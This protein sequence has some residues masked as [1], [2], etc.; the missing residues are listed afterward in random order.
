MRVPGWMSRRE[1]SGGNYPFGDLWN[2]RYVFMKTNEASGCPQSWCSVDASMRLAMEI[3][4][5]FQRVAFL[6]SR[7][8]L[9]HTRV[10]G[11][12]LR[13]SISAVY[14]EYHKAKTWK[15]HPYSPHMPRFDSMVSPTGSSSSL[16][17]TVSAGPR[18]L[19]PGPDTGH[20]DPAGSGHSAD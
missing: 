16:P 2:R 11:S 12:I 5:R 15:R 14:D 20:D 13:L 1:A 3:P 4:K 17:T 6:V 19:A 7:E 10:W 18:L 9:R 8:A